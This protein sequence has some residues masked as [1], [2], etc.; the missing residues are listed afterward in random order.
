VSS[1]YA[2]RDPLV[3]PG[4]VVVH[5]DGGSKDPPLQ[6]EISTTAGLKTRRYQTEISTT[7]GLK[8]RRYQTELSA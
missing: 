1:V 7:A 4:F 8:T 5:D 2:R 3:K 6:T